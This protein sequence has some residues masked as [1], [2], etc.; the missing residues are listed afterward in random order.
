MAPA[1]FSLF[2]R[3]LPRTRGCLVAAGI[4]A[5][6]CAL[7]TL[8]FSPDLV[9]WLGRAVP[10][11]P[12]TKRWLAGFRFQGDVWAVPE[13]TPVFADEPLLEVEAPLPVAQLVETLVMNQVHL[14]TVVASK[15][16]RVVSAARGRPILDFGMRRA[17][18]LDAA[19]QGA[20]AMYLAG[21]DATSDVLAGYVYGLPLAGT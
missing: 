17:Q 11:R 15:A 1:V 10:L 16:V 9:E 4:D 14:A 12:A 7:E 2:C 3:A 19:L 6:L 20:R 13:G 8:S 5:V 21:G 18:G